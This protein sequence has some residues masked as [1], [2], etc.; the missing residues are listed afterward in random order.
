MVCTEGKI[1]S[2]L[3]IEIFCTF[4]HHFGGSISKNLVK[5]Q[6]TELTLRKSNHHQQIERR[7]TF[8]RYTVWKRGPTER[9][10]S[11]VGLPG[12]IGFVKFHP[13]R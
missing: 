8:C 7:R 5:I 3:L 13:S 2:F 10:P 1:L 12:G 4:C 6:G 9:C 11:P